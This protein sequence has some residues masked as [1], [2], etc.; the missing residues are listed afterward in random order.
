MQFANTA[1]PATAILYDS[2][3]GRN[4]DSVLALGLLHG[5]AGKTQCRVSALS[6]NYPCL[7]AAQLCDVVERFYRKPV[8]DPVTAYIAGPAI[9]IVDSAGKTIETPALV[10][11]TLAQKAEA[12]KP[13]WQSSIKQWNDTAVPEILMRN[14]LAAQYDGNAVMV[15][16]GAATNLTRLL[17]LPDVKPLVAAKVK[18]L[19]IAG[20]RFAPGKADGAFASDMAAAKKLLA[21]WP[22]PIVF[23]GREIGEQLP[24]P[25][26][27]IEND[28]SY[29]PAHP[30]VDAYRACGPMPHDAPTCALAAMLQAIR[31][32]DGYFSMSKPGTISLAAD[33]KTVF[34]EGATGKHSYLSAVA[35]KHDEVIQKFTENVSAKPVFPNPRGKQN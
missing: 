12:D 18:M 2:D 4:I 35:E 32:N 23:C 1:K 22:T 14:N 6:I 9:G 29:A 21:E 30:V 19:V 17:A 8:A 7:P 13:K 24:F 31:Q 10:K 33:G 34:T 28:F 16:T 25:S 15:L 20:G 27:C 11:E 5:F 26:K 3:F